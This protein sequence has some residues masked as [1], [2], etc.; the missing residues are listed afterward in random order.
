MYSER[1]SGQLC[2]WPQRGSHTLTGEI[3]NQEANL[4]T[5]AGGVGEPPGVPARGLEE[6]E[7]GL[8]RQL[9]SWAGPGNAPAPRWKVT[10]RG[11]SQNGEVRQYKQ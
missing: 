11:D 3:V 7:Q 9:A 8:E 4:G 1:A 5:P 2:L 6:R 10:I